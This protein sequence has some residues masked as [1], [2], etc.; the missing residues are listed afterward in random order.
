MVHVWRRYSDKT[1]SYFSRKKV[2]AVIF[3]LKLYDSSRHHFNNPKLGR[4]YSLGSYCLQP[5][6]NK[7]CPVIGMGK[8]KA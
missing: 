3:T 1:G 8:R 6:T 7:V 4:Q 2:S 5:T